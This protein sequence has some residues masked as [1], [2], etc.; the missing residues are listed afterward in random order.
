MLEYFPK[1]EISFYN[2]LPRLSKKN[3]KLNLANVI[4]KLKAKLENNDKVINSL[5]KKNSKN[6]YSVS[7]FIKTERYQ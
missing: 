5:I 2:T 6:N 4:P 3:R 7:F 1:T